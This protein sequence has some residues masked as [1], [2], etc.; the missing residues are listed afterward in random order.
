MTF[1]RLEVSANGVD[2]VCLTAGDGPLALCL[3]GFPDTAWSYR[4]LLPALA[5]PPNV[6]APQLPTLGR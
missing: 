4:F 3:H 6:L 2:F 5:A 1:E